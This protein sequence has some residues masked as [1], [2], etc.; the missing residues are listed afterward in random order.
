MAAESA[1]EPGRR[2]GVHCGGRPS[3]GGAGSAEDFAGRGSSEEESSHGAGGTSCRDAGAGGCGNTVPRALPGA[4]RGSGNLA[5]VSRCAE[6]AGETLNRDELGGRGRGRVDTV[7]VKLVEGKGLRE[8]PH[9][10]ELWKSVEKARR[11]LFA[12]SPKRSAFLSLPK[13]LPQVRLARGLTLAEAVRSRGAA[14]RR[15]RKCK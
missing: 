8:G 14:C 15:I 12:L 7:G 4:G 13:A 1:G 6:V 9:S 3:G 11:Y 2:G 5:G 10:K